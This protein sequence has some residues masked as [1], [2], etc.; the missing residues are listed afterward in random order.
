MEGKWLWSTKPG[1]DW[2][3]VEEGVVSQR[4]TKVLSPKAAG[5]GVRG[6]AKQQ[7][8]DVPTLLLSH[9]STETIPWLAAVSIIS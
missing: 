6:Q 2:V 4:K 3:R 8:M 7:S 1:A 9:S 5:E